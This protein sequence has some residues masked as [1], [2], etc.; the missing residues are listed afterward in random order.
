MKL[1]IKKDLHAVNFQLI[2][3]LFR[4]WANTGCSS[5]VSYDLHGMFVTY[6]KPCN[7]DLLLTRLS[8]SSVLRHVSFVLAAYWTLLN[9]FSFKNWEQASLITALTKSRA[10]NWKLRD[11]TIRVKFSCLHGPWLAVRKNGMMPI[12]RHALPF[13]IDV[14]KKPMGTI[15]TCAF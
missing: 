9:E 10:W 6:H 1:T 13:N 14:S 2:P 4:E 11:D 12:A 5:P 15:L 7:S 8:N 3:N